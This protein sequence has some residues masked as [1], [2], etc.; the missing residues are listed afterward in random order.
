MFDGCSIN[1]S[2]LIYI[3]DYINDISS[4]DK[5]TDE[6]WKMILGNDSTYITKTVRGQIH[7]DHD[8]NIEK[9]ILARNA[10]KMIKKGWDVYYHDV[11]QEFDETVEP[12][13]PEIIDPTNND[14][15][16]INHYAPDASKWN[17]EV[18]QNIKNEVK[19]VRVIDKVAYDDVNDIPSSY[20][21]VSH[22]GYVP[23]AST[24]NEHVYSPNSDILKITHVINEVAYDDDMDV[25]SNAIANNGYVPDASKWNEEI[26]AEKGL[27]VTR[28]I[29]GASYE[30]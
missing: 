12:D 16:I 7:I 30:N 28:V 29:D 27:V 10:N 11:L 6:D 19:I 2:S 5:E 3:A 22:N 26:Y 1:E 24:W 9:D 15:T 18:Y 21:V 25:S 17:E 4:L 8:T 13:I 14:V 20:D 23:D